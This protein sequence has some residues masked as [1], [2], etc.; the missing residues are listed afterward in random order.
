LNRTA[1][2]ASPGIPSL[3]FVFLKQ[4]PSSNPTLLRIEAP[5][6]ASDLEDCLS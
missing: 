1:N 4:F 2:N 5:V 6:R 3:G